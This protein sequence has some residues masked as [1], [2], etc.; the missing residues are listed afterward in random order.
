MA[1]LN[2]MDRE[3]VLREYEIK[4]DVTTIGRE[5]NNK[6]VVADSSVSRLHALLEKREDGYYLVDKNSSNGCFVNGKK[7]TVQKLNH[8]DKINLGNAS[9]VF[10]DESQVQATFI[11][12]PETELTVED[13]PTEAV[14]KSTAPAPPAPPA[15]HRS[16]PPPVPP[17]SPAPSAAKAPPPVPP[18]PVAPPPPK[19]EAAPSV[20]PSCKKPVEPKAKFC[21]FC[22]TAIAPPKVVEAPK[23]AT[24][25][26]PPQ[27]S[28]P[29]VAAAPPPLKSAPSVPASA[30]PVG[31]LNYASFGQRLIAYLLDGLIIGALTLIPVAISVVGFV[32]PIQRQQEPG[33][34]AMVV[35]G[36]C[37]ILILLITLGYYVYFIGLKGATPGKKIMKLKVTLPDGQYPV[38][39]GKALVR[40][41]GYAISAMICYIGFL[42]AAFD[43]EEHRALHDRIA[44]TRVIRE[45]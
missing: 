6:V 39:V 32:I 43:K 29:P 4:E 21:G 33:P 25:P 13:R 7:I 24:P 3:N 14:F 38:G 12:R 40:F 5:A 10:E 41:I 27:P 45:A 17:P 37:Q 20:C 9:L 8:S 42:M 36:I 16:T 18:P 22:G 31:S 11:L 15:P 34:M 28:K 26:P 19:V 23:P 2:F 35:F 44:G 1:K 30:A